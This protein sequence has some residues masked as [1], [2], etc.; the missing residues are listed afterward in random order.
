MAS[1]TPPEDSG[2]DKTS[3]SDSDFYPTHRSGIDH[4]TPI[5]EDISKAYLIKWI[6]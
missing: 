4:S 2:T 3:D 6:M 1:S 5:T